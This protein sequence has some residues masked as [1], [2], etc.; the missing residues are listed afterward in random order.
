MLNSLR[1][2]LVSLFIFERVKCYLRLGKL[3]NAQQKVLIFWTEIETDYIITQLK[4]LL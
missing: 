1:Y 2:C 4:I 3:Q